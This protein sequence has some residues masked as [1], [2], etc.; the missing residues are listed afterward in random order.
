[1]VIPSLLQV[2]KVRD[3]GATNF[4]TGG[5]RTGSSSI[6]GTGM[7][8]STGGTGMLGSSTGAGGFSNK[9]GGKGALPSKGGKG[10]SKTQ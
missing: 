5:A 3:V 2:M 4:S 6:A 1:V 7:L 8:G 9:A 10:Y